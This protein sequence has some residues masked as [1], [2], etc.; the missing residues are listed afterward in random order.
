MREWSSLI[1]SKAAVQS[2]RGPCGLGLLVVIGL[3]QGCSGGGGAPGAP[4]DGGGGGGDDDPP[5]PPH[6]DA[7]YGV[8]DVLAQVEVAAPITTRFILRATL[9][10]PPELYPLEEE[11]VSPFAI[12]D[13]LGNEVNAQVEIVSRYPD[14]T[15]GADV[16]E[17]LASVERPPGSLIGDRLTYSVI[18]SPNYPVSHYITD[19]VRQLVETPE[20]LVLRTRDVFGHWY[21]AD[22]LTDYR[23]EDPDELVVMRDG[24]AA[25]QVRTHET[26]F[27]RNPTSG[28]TGT[29]PHMMGVHTYLTTWQSENFISID[30]RVHNGHDGHDQTTDLDDP[31]G[32]VYFDGLELVAPTGWTLIHAFPCPTTGLRYTEGS[33]EVWPLIASIG[34]GT[35]HVMHAQQMFH[36]RLVLAR[37]GHENSAVSA[38]EEQGLGFCRKGMTG[39]G[40]ELFSWWNTQTARYWPQNLPLP[41]LEYMEPMTSS[42]NELY[43]DF[44][45]IRQAL[46][47]GTPGPWPVIEGNIGWAHPWGPPFG[48][49]HGGS[50][51]Y[52]WDGVKT[53]WSASN[54][55]Y[56][57][58][59]ATHR[60]YTE[61][62]PTALYDEHGG[63]HHLEDWI[64][65]GA[66]GDYLPTWMWL[67]PQLYLGDAFGF[68]DTP[69]F[70]VDAVAAQGRAPDY[71]ELL[72]SFNEIDTQ[73]LIRY[74]RSPK[75][76]AW[77]GNDAL[78]KDDLV[79]QG[80][81]CR[82]SYTMLPQTE[83]GQAI[84]IGAL[85]A[86]R[87][88]D[89]HPGWGFDIDRGHGWI[90]DAA[91][92]AY[93]F[94]DVAWRDEVRSWYVDYVDLVE[95]GQ[96]TCT[97]AMQS[98][99]NGNHFG[100]QYRVLQS[101]SE[102]IIQN[103]IWGMR[104]TVFGDH[105][106][107]T[108]ARIDSVLAGSTGAMISPLV[109][110]EAG[111]VPFFYT[112]LGPMDDDLPPF[113]T[114][115]PP[116]GEEGQDGWQTWNVYVFGLLATGDAYYLERARQMAGGVLTVEE[117]GMDTHTGELETRAGMIS[118][119]QSLE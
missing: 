52:F 53:A 99:P 7:N 4:G 91:A 14:P 20:S 100:A 114:Y 97:G 105:D 13:S 113:C 58:F 48:A 44:E 43:Y 90:L 18:W 98:T 10:V 3:L 59:Q 107:T 37:S 49:M 41:D 72:E 56:R 102:C 63:P 1:G 104:T 101:I 79:L 35:L 23:D 74:T 77:L 65:E 24:T 119:L 83:G 25:H 75:V 36:R 118:L 110:D 2:A 67:T 54:D 9:P 6:V 55:G 33:T 8:G 28:T 57:M 60:M 82:A 51:I 109:W 108:V 15:D 88:V 84:I 42:R 17:V 27:P 94:G 70:Q 92:A 95:D 39:E 29:L 12:R 38:V 80:E 40:F 111:D 11:G 68:L 71:D 5:D 66:N 21:E 62:H 115:V 106:P 47:A 85:D 50:E 22:L 116:D 61:R 117:I 96:S 64:V 34:G 93:A 81:L 103:A 76:L 78:A 69:T 45:E 31:A 86:R 87:Y 112:A 32:T 19:N 46:R 73:H 16:V 26:L 30:V 89:L